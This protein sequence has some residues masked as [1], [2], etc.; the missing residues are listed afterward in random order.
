MIPDK[1]N[2]Q[3][4]IE[5]KA[6][7]LYV[8]KNSNNMQVA[9]T[10]Y[11]GRIVSI[12]F[13][14]KEH[15]LIDVTLG[16]DNLSSY[17]KANEPYF[18]AIIGRYGNRI[19][20]G[21]FTLEGKDYSLAINNGLNSL[22]G[23]PTGFSSR[24]W[25]G[26]MLSDKILE[27]SYFS[28][29]G[30]ESFPGNLNVKVVYTLTDDNSIKIDYTA[31]SDQTTIVNLTN[32]AYFNLNGE[33]K[34]DITDHIL[35]L[36]ANQFTPIDEGFI[37]TGELRSVDDSAFDFRS[38]M[39][40]GEMISKSDIQLQYANGFDHN[41]MI[42]G[43]MHVLREAAIVTGPRT[44]IKMEVLTTEPGMQFYTGNFLDGKE[45]DGKGGNAYHFRSGFCLE[46]Q[47]FPDS[48]NQPKFPSTILKA[49]DTYQTTTVYKFGTV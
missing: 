28:E 9:I 4:T 24:V 15:N 34:G 23:G 1:A 19:A 48:P 32:H 6:T 47:H 14:D 13:P 12:L 8:L 20:K 7:D 16:Y 29:D 45:K 41:F 30:E 5:G 2:F 38:P 35:Q 18:G 17:R 27:L 31:V 26:E 46:T 21:K 25:D 37:P 49:G 3:D 33:S 42:M 36:N 39:A 44:G 22:H 40:I 11:G 10:N 43:E